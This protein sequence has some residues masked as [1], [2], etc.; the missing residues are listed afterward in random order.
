MLELPTPKED[1]LVIP[2]VGEWSRDKHHFLLRYIDAFTTA[3]RDKRWHGLHYIDLFAGAGIERLARS[4]RL[5]WGSPLLAAQTRYPFDRLHLC[6][7]NPRKQ[8]ALKTRLE[9]LS[10]APRFQT[11]LGDAND[12]VGEIVRAI[13]PKT[14]SLAFLD[15]YGLHLDYGTLEQ[16]AQIRADLVI[17][18]PDRVDA[19]RNWRA[20]YWD[21]PDSNLDRVLGPG[22][23]WRSELAEAPVHRRTETLLK[24][25]ETQIR[26][27]GYAEFEWEPIPSWGARLYWLIFCSRHKAGA[28]IW[29][30]TSQK[31]ADS[32]QTFDFG[33]S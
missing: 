6:E 15:P 18:F 4:N 17:Y 1:G 8:H 19:D 31:K 3:M 16:L 22:V 9:G 21:N 10:S 27:L 7:K 32:Q 26:K 11:L 25:Y 30:G 20:Y 2:K 5:D 12:K 14:L 24:L 29:R 33:A 28:K 23:D 13:P